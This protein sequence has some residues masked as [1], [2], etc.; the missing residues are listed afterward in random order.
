MKRAVTSRKKKTVLPPLGPE[1]RAELALWL[2]KREAKLPDVVNAA[3]VHYNELVDA[4]AGDR[5]RLSSLLIRLRLAMKIIAS[6]EKRKGSGDPIGATTKPDDAKPKN[7]KERLHLSLSRHDGLED[8]HKGMARKHRR[9]AKDITKK[10]MKLEDIELTAEELAQ[11]KAEHAEYMARLALG[12]KADPALE[13]PK[14]AFM[15]GGSAQVE[16]E[17][18]VAEVN[19]ALLEG[20]KIVSRLTEE[21]TRYSFSLTVSTVAIDVEKVVVKDAE[22]GTRII[23]ASTREIGPPQMDVTWEFLANM[24]IMASQYAT[25]LNRLANLLTLPGKRFSSAMLSKMFCYN[26]HRFLPIYLYNFRCLANA[27]LLSGDDTKNR[28]LEYVRYLKALVGNPTEMPD[29]PWLDYATRSAAEESFKREA[30]PGLGILTSRELGFE[31]SRKDGNGAKKGLQTSVIWGRGEAEDPRSTIIFYRSH[32]GGYGNLLTTC[33]ALR[34]PELKKILIQSDL[35]S[36][37]LVTDAE[38][39]K[40]FIIEMAG[41]TSHARRPFAIFEEQD[42]DLCAHMLHLFRG[43]YIYERGLD[44]FGRN[45]TNVRAVRG[46]DSRQMWEEIKELA[47]I[48]ADKW[49]KETNL[50]DA[51]RY[52]LRHYAKLTAYL[53]NPMLSISNDFSERLLRPENLIEANALFRNSLEGRFALDINRSVLQTAIAARAPVSEYA[54]YVLRAP[55]EA[56]AAHPEEFTALAYIRKFPPPAQEEPLNPRDL[57]KK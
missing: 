51:A 28:V 38:L 52:I 9:K 12:E 35:S 56:V 13:P 17:C 24:A 34:R 55:P 21:R 23:S 33:L 42:P 44:L 4:L 10:L 31:S 1:E 50:G 47:T 39:I 2:K 26:A 41:C 54:Q 43:L 11:D 48:C 14:H 40:R 20:Q 29:P 30:K 32:I 8:W 46:T 5:W 7:P 16:E 19:P 15:Q 3:F 57:L 6:S 37:N 45:D 49:S 27:P 25:P 53:E 22:S 36:V 18:A